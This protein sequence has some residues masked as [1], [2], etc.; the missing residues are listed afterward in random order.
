MSTRLC[1]VL[2]DPD[3]DVLGQLAEH[4]QQGLLVTDSAAALNSVV[5]ECVR[6]AVEQLEPTSEMLEIMN[7][8]H[9]GNCFVAKRF[10]LIVSLALFPE[11]RAY[12][13]ARCPTHKFETWVESLPTNLE[14]FL[15]GCPTDT[16]TKK[17]TKEMAAWGKN[18]YPTV[19]AFTSKLVSDY[20]MR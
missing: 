1:E 5:H 2:E 17:S 20:L 15:D 7:R 18:E 16:E 4:K 19:D 8:A 12:Y 6:L 14:F 3:R 10:M 9:S 11:V 13:R